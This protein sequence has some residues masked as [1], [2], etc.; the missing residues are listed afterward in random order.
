MTTAGV[1]IV[2][3]GTF[4]GGTASGAVGF[5]MVLVAAPLVSLV[6]PH[7]LPV[8]F[9]APSLAANLTVTTAERR[10][11]DLALLGRLLVWQVPGMALGLYALT[12]IADVDTLA[13][14][15]A[16]MVM[17]MVAIGAMPW[18]PRR[19]RVTEALAASTAGFAGA[20]SSTDGPPLAVLMADDD[21]RL[22]R[23]TLPALFVVAQLLLLPGW[24]LA[25]V[26]T[27]EAI[28][29]GVVAIPAAWAGAMVG[30]RVARRFLTPARVRGVVLVLATV[31]AAR[32]LIARLG[33]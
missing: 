24:A 15:V 2:V 11:R 21:P 17:A 4:L 13:L 6:A 31:A 3:L 1:A 16:G 12:R 10:H 14:V 7:L 30:H 33:G 26:L 9:A 20:L 29:T 25:G 22:M 18:R 19:N 28:V 5:G 8:V 27:A 23:A 32:A